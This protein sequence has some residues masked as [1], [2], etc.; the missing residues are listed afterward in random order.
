[1]ETSIAHRIAEKLKSARKVLL[2]MHRRPDPD[3]M[4]SAAAMAEFLRGHGVPFQ[5]FCAT[6]FPAE[7]ALFGIDTANLIT[8]NSSLITQ[9]DVVCAFDAGDLEHAG[10]APPLNLP[11]GK[12]EK[13]EDVPP[14]YKGGAQGGSPCLIV[15]DHHSTNAH[16][17]NLNAVDP[18]AA[19]T[20]EIVYDFFQKV[21]FPVS[22]RAAT[23]LLA[24][25]LTDTDY[26]LN[27]GTTASSLK[28]SGEL[29]AR[30]VSLTQLRSLLFERR[31]LSALKL[32]GEA[33]TRLKQ[34]PRLGIAVT[35]VTAEDLQ[36]HNLGFEDL[37]GISNLLNSI[38]DARATLLLKAQDGLVRGSLRTTRQGVD[39]GRL[40]AALGG[41]GHKKAA[42]FSARGTLQVEGG[43]VRVL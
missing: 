16:F 8:H 10:L 6:P 30:G 39:V 42:G 7:A 41:G 29:I 18:N 3:T 5:Y 20:T 28:I 14:P 27:P 26:F 19:A 4:G 24:G 31:G 21:G 23:Y 37:E 12:G 2:V 11:L 15:F 17:G 13:K 35:Y 22:A 36:K 9:F 32:M 25:L 40:A 33:L 34:H 1:M 43:R 38:G